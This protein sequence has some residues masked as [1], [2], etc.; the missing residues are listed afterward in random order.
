MMS[1]L[2]GFAGRTLTGVTIGLASITAVECALA[3][4]SNQSDPMTS[5]LLQSAIA[6]GLLP[7]FNR[8]TQPTNSDGIDLTAP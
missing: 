4:T 3:V 7:A 1:E 6:R 8:Q 2:T 5:A